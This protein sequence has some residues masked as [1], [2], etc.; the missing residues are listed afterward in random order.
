MLLGFLQG[1][2]Y[3][4]QSEA[5]GHVCDFTLT[6]VEYG[7]LGSESPPVEQPPEKAR[8]ISMTHQ[9]TEVAWFLLNQTDLL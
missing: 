9:P 5:Q 4:L 3:L 7:V 8:N 6:H 1:Y 2:S